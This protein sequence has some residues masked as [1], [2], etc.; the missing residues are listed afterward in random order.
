MSEDNNSNF[1]WRI[2]YKNFNH[3]K[4]GSSNDFNKKSY[5]DLD[6]PQDFNHKPFKGSKDKESDLYTLEIINGKIHTQT[7][8]TLFVNQVLLL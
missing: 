5:D 2:F 7:N 1:S 3:L 8:K 4:D 6:K